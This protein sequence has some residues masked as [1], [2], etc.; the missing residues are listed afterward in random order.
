MAKSSKSSFVQGVSEYS[1]KT[2]IGTELWMVRDMITEIIVENF[3][4]IKKLDLPLGQIQTALVGPNG[5]GK[6]SVLQAFYVLAQSCLIRHGR[7]PDYGASRIETRGPYIDLGPSED[8]INHE[9]NG[10][11]TIG[12]RARVAAPTGFSGAHQVPFDFFLRFSSDGKWAQ[13]ATFD[14]LGT[15]VT[16]SAGPG[17]ESHV[18]TQE[19]PI[20]ELKF[21]LGPNLSIGTPIS[22]KIITAPEGTETKAREI[23]AQLNEVFSSPRRCFER[24]YPVP[25]VRAFDRYEYTFVDRP[26]DQ[27]VTSEGTTEQARFTASA[28]A[29]KKLESRISYWMKSITGLEIKTAPTPGPKIS[30]ETTGTAPV[31][32]INEGF[33]TNQLVLLLAQLASSPPES[34]I[35]I[36]E[37]E[38]H[39]HPRAQALLIDLLTEVAKTEKKQIIFATHSDHVVFRLLTQVAEGRLHSPDDIGVYAFQKRDLTTEVSKLKVDD[40]GRIE[41][42]LHDFFE[43]DVEGFEKF[44]GAVGA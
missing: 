18:S 23:Q 9:S 26:V 43:A 29:Y 24:I 40:K 34:L 36:E 41:G 1:G 13:E 30:V 27:M 20:D 8:L 10:I 22:V 35:V 32:I 44:L 33:G 11:A 15:N 16:V 25:S 12:V 3:K 4:S 31:N 5:S 2:G 21:G 6:S 28:I 14:L 17:Q 38:A 39:L 42:G 19:L 37:P 7:M